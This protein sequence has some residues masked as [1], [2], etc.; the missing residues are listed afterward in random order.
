MEQC[1][2]KFISS[3]NLKIIVS[4]IASCYSISNVFRLI[5]CSIFGQLNNKLKHFMII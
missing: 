2:E 1:W 3:S 5:L 4:N